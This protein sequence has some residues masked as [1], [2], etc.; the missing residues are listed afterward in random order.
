MVDPHPRQ[1]VLFEEGHDH[2]PAAEER[3]QRDV[4]DAEVAL[5]EVGRGGL[6]LRLFEGATVVLLC[7]ALLIV[8]A[9]ATAAAAAAAAAL[10][11]AVQSAFLPQ[12]PLDFRSINRHFCSILRRKNGHQDQFGIQTC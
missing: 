2:N 7:S 12:Q 6:D 8:S 9:T 5:R 3:Q 11:A 4:G 10:P 1:P